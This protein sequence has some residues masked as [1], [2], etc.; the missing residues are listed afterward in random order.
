MDLGV[1][2]HGVAAPAAA[3]RGGVCRFDLERRQGRGCAALLWFLAALACKTSVVM[4]PAVLLLFAWWRRG[5]IGIGDLRDAAPFFGASAAMG[6]ATV[7]FQSTRAIG[8]SGTPAGLAGRVGQA[9]WSVLSYA[10]QCVWPSDLAPIYPPAGGSIP[11]IVP[12]LGDRGGPRASLGLPGGLGPARPPRVGLV[13][14]QPRC[15]SS[16]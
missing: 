13:P 1:Q 7:W 14:P 15:P 3:C 16:G 5:R 4:F 10:R 8:I 6:A 12:W 11:G 2:E 9:G